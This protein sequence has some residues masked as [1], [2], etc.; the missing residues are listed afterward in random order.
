MNKGGRV[1][2]RPMFHVVNGDSTLALLHKAAIPG[3]FM[4][5]PDM[6]MEGT[7][8]QACARQAP[9]LPGM[10]HLPGRIGQISPR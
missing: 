9:Y 8:Q 10:D 5:W 4:V 1:I 7:R 3:E 2:S 6:L